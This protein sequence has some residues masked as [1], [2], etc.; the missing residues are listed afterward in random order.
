[1]AGPEPV[2]TA[3]RVGLQL[4]SVHSVPHRSTLASR[5]DVQRTNMPL[6]RAPA[7]WT[8]ILLLKRPQHLE[9]CHKNAKTGQHLTRKKTTN[10]P[11]KT[12]TRSPSR[13]SRP[14]S[15]NTTSTHPPLAAWTSA[16]KPSSTSPKRPR[17]C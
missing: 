14:C 8:M 9:G 15:R 13:S 7:G 1:M 4:R 17:L 10:N 12:S 11:G 6:W 5:R 2:R 16:P 3:L